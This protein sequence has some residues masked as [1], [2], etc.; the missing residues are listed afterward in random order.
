MPSDVIKV[1]LISCGEGM[2]EVKTR[3]RATSQVNTAVIQMMGPP[4]RERHDRK[5]N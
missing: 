4:G 2:V 3:S 5:W 1:T